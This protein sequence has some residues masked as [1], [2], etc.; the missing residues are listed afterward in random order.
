MDSAATVA[1]TDLDY[2]AEKFYDGWSWEPGN[3]DFVPRTGITVK[4]R[5]KG[6]R[7][8]NKTSVYCDPEQGQTPE[9]L[10]EQLPTIVQALV[11]RAAS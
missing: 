5:R 7:R 8:W 6:E 3:S 11:R 2:Q 9:S 4:W 1:L 10:A